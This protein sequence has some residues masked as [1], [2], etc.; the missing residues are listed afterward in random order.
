[1]GFSASAD[2]LDPKWATGI[3][4][5]SG[6]ATGGGALKFD[7]KDDYVNCG[8]INAIDGAT[9]ITIENWAKWGG[10]INGSIW[11]WYNQ[12]KG[13]VY[14][15]ENGYSGDSLHKISFTFYDGATWYS[16]GSI[17]N[18]DDGKWH[19]IVGVY[20]GAY[21]RIYIDGVQENFNNVGAKTFN[22]TANSVFLGSN[23]G[24]SAFWKGI[25][26]D[27]RVYNY[28]RTQEQIMQDYNAGL[29]THFK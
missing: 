15:L 21:V 7:G 19:H 17:T 22:S 16:A 25:I 11:H 12:I 18:I 26:D 29:S 3:K 6:G 5:L 28:A 9:K 4:P 2:A 23:G 14:G 1:L 24:T 27:V 10:D 20:D 13:A 8:D